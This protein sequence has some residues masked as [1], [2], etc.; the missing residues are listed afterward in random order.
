MASFISLRDGLKTRL[1]AITSLN[2]YDTIPET[3]QPPAAIV[4]GPMGK[5]F[6]IN[7]SGRMPK[8]MTEWVIPIWVLVQ[9]FDAVT[10]QDELDAYLASTGTR[11]IKVAIE[12]DKTLGGAAQTCRVAKAE[13]YTGQYVEFKIEIIA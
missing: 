1:A 9:P 4:G 13:N 12:G 8:G 3:P 11:S 2:V 6:Q 7:Y 10:A 5:E